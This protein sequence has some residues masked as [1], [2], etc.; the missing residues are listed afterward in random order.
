MPNGL[1]KADMITPICKCCVHYIFASLF[2]SL[3][4]G[5]CETKKN[6][7]QEKSFHSWDNQVLTFQIFKCYDAIKCPSMKYQTH[8]NE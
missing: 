8:F 7:F 1:K 6:V 4:E 2:L 3:K 5:T